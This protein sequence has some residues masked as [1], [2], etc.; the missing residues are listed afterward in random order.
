MLK[1]VQ[2]LDDDFGVVVRGMVGLCSL[3][4]GG[5]VLAETS[6]NDLTR[7][8]DFVQFLNIQISKMGEYTFYF[9]GESLKLSAMMKVGS[10]SNTDRELYVEIGACTV[11][12]NTMPVVDLRNAFYLLSTWIVCIK[13]GV[14][15]LVYDAWMWLLQMLN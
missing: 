5:V 8:V 14:S 10:I 2:W 3:V 12:V 6:L 9:C 15:A 1:Y 7:Q 13:Q 4:I 11:K